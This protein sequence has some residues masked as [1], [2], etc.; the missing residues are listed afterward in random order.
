MAT[1]GLVCPVCHR[2]FPGDR[3]EL[4]RAFQEVREA[5]RRHIGVQA[6]SLELYALRA[7]KSAVVYQ[8]VFPGEL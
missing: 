5:V 2:P 4:D 7:L 8:T 1:E 3:P 6:F